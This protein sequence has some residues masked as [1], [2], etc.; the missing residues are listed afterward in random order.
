M[1]A[2]RGDGGA[3]AL[4]LTAEMYWRFVM[5]RHALNSIVEPRY[6]EH[7]LL[8]VVPEINGTSQTTSIFLVLRPI[9]T[10][11]AESGTPPLSCTI[12][13]RSPRANF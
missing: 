12:T 2:G 1:F 9:T 4:G 10:P 5:L 3:C 8:S 7:R 6:C 11:F 13:T